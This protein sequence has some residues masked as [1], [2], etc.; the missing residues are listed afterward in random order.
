[1]YDK[2]QD[3]L[4]KIDD[5]LHGD[6][7]DAQKNAG[8]VIQIKEMLNSIRECFAEEEEVMIKNKDSRY[9]EHKERH[10]S[11]LVNYVELLKFLRKE[12]NTEVLLQTV[13]N[14]LLPSIVEHITQID[15]DFLNNM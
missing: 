10:S 8:K 12:G 1:M 5:I 3:L 7:S 6:D 13:R 14:Q 11:I 4:N 15:H 2:H 9:D